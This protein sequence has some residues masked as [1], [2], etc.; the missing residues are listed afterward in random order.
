MNKHTDDV[1]WEAS[2]LPI[3][4]LIEIRLVEMSLRQ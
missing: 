1:L 4:N 2:L 3:E